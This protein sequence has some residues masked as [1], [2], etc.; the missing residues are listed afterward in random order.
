MGFKDL[1]S[2]TE[3]TINLMSE[4]QLPALQKDEAKRL[5]RSIVELCKA[6]NASIRNTS[7][8]LRH[9]ANDALSVHLLP[10]WFARLRY[11]RNLKDVEKELCKVDSVKP[12]LSLLVSLLH[13]HTNIETV[14]RY[15]RKGQ[16][17]PQELVKLM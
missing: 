3:S 17:P 12:S 14:T 2:M 4:N 7:R 13:L 11:A 8:G 1:L 10:R 5:M 6:T 9:L 16:E 15:Q